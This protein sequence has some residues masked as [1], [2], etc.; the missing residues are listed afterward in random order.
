MGD[1]T[2]PVVCKAC[3]EPHPDYRNSLCPTPLCTG[4]QWV[5]EGNSDCRPRF[6]DP[7]YKTP[8]GDW[9]KLPPTP[10]L[11]A[12]KGAFKC[13]EHPQIFVEDKRRWLRFEATHQFA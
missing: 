10:G 7:S 1:E 4:T 5:V 9:V 3:K 2:R 12:P 13:T 6:D 11:S 8:L